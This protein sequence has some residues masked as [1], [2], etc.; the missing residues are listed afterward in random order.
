MTFALSFILGKLSLEKTPLNLGPKL[1]YL[2][3]FILIKGWSGTKKFYL[4]DSHY[5]IFFL[6]LQHLFPLSEH[7][8]QLTYFLALKHLKFL[9]TGQEIQLLVF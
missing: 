4:R 3:L 9:I 2:V 6:L 8:I 7:L 1:K 5:N